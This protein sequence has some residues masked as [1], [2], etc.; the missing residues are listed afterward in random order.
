VNDDDTRV[1]HGIMITEDPSDDRIT[2]VR[3]HLAQAQIE[4]CQA[5]ESLVFDVRMLEKAVKTMLSS[6]QPIGPRLNDL[7]REY[8]MYLKREVRA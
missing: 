5:F 7:R 8:D 2:R 3:E 4:N 6:N 1:T